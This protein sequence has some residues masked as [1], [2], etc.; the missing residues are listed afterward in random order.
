MLT[1]KL[2]RYG[3]KHQPHYRVVVAEARSKREGKAVAIL[4]F[5]NPKEKRVKIDKKA[6]E[7]W[8]QQGAQPT[9][10]VA[11]LVK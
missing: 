8:R 4:G 2:A 11:K 1:I 5:W 10:S 6:Y 3:K 7:K 9:E